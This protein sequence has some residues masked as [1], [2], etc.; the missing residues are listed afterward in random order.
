MGCVESA[1]LKRQL[2]ELQASHT[3]LEQEAE[4]LREQ[5]AKLDDELNESEQDIANLRKD[6]QVQDETNSKRL[7]VFQY[8]FEVLQKMVMH[9]RPTARVIATKVTTT[10]LTAGHRRR[11]E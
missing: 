10:R 8:K 2:E 6:R 9:Q 7:L 4:T 3:T 1:H 11:E 5:N